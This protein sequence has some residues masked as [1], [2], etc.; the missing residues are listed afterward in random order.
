MSRLLDARE[1][2]GEIKIQAAS[3]LDGALVQ[4]DAEIRRFVGD[5]GYTIWQTRSE[6][7]LQNFA[8]NVLSWDV[9]VSWRVTT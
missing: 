3:T 7:L 9:E 2:F 6:P 8:G 5:R 1:S 4:A